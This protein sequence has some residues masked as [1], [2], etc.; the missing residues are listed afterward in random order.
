MHHVV[1]SYSRATL[2]VCNICCTIKKHCKTNDALYLC[3]LA[4]YC[5]TDIIKYDARD[6]KLLVK[7]KYKFGLYLLRKKSSTGLSLTWSSDGFTNPES[8]NPNIFHKKEC[9]YVHLTNKIT[10]PL[11]TEE[12]V[13]NLAITNWR[14]FYASWLLTYVVPISRFFVKLATFTSF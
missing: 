11:Q 2:F 8:T 7:I 14:H 9:F 1:S 13:I 6:S 5:L 3:N 10:N 12:L 4:L